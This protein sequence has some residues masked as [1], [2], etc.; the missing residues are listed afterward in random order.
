MRNREFE[1]RRAK[2][3]ANACYLFVASV[4]KKTIIKSIG[5]LVQYLR[6]LDFF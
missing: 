6:N 4:E 3:Y 5:A 2:D 1:M